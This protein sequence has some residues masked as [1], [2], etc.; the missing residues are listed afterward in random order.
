MKKHWRNSSKVA[1]SLT[2]LSI[3]LFVVLGMP[4]Y[5][6]ALETS[7]GSAVEEY[8]VLAYQAAN[9]KKAFGDDVRAVSPSLDY[10]EKQYL[11]T[12]QKLDR[13][14]IEVGIIFALT[15]SK[16]EF[17]EAV[18]VAVVLGKVG[19][20]DASYPAIKALRKVLLQKVA[21]E[22]M[23]EN[24]PTAR[25][26]SLKKL[27]NTLLGEDRLRNVKEKPA[28]GKSQIPIY[29][30]FHWHMHQPV[31]W[32]YEDMVTT[33]N[34]GVYSFSLLDVMRSRYGPYTSWPFESI[35][36]GS[37]AELPH[38]G[39]QVSFSGA[40]IEDLN[41]MVR[42]G[43]FQNWY[44][45]YT[46]GRRL[47][48]KLGNPRLDLVAFGYHHPL[49]PLTG[50]EDIRRQIRDHKK[51]IQD[52]FGSDVSYSKGIFPP[53]N[54]FAEWIIPA[55]VDEGIEW[56][57]VDNIHFNR[58]CKNYPWVKGENLFPP[59]RADQTNPEQENWIQLSGLWAPSKVS[60]WAYQP[61]Y[62][63]LQDPDT[64]KIVKTPDG[65][66]A[67]MVAVPT[68]R[69]MGNEDGRGGFGALNYEQVMSQLMEY[70]TDPA[71][72][73]LIVLHHDGDNF[74]GGSWGYY[75]DNF[76]RFTDW[77]K[78]RSDLFV[79]T[80]VQDYLQ[81]FPPDD[82]DIIHVEPGSWAG[83][84]NGDPEFHKWNGDPDPETGY[85]PDRNSWGTMT[86]ARN[87]VFT[88]D[89][90]AGSG[91]AAVEGAW[92]YML[93][94]QTSCYEY[95]DGTEMWDSH[96]TRACNQAVAE[97]E[98]VLQG[99][100][101]DRVPPSIYVPQ[102]EPYNP[103]GYEWTAE[104]MSKDFTVWTY[105]YDVSGLEAVD[106]EFRTSDEDKWIS[107]PLAGKDIPSQTNPLP[108]VKA[109]EYTMVIN[110][111]TDKTYLY[112]VKAEDTHGNIGVSPVMKVTVGAAS[113]EP[114]TPVWIPPK[115]T[116]DDII[117][118]FSDRPGYLHWGVNGWKKPA[119]IYWP[120]DSTLWTDGVAIETPMEVFP[121]R[122][123]F[124]TVIGPFNKD[125]QA[126]DSVEFV[127][128]YLDGSWGKDMKISVQ[129][130]P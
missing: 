66:Q 77:I 62:V 27:N 99:K 123:G 18:A 42:L 34:K 129:V 117:I 23:E 84:D 61:H 30:A 24:L 83:A 72:P 22:L 124:Q 37:E 52:T 40:L 112:R 54:A 55:L 111:E 15:L 96:P 63:V 100:Y 110:G 101:D 118:V 47:S 107:H 122:G 7:L 17:N 74:G 14:R 21:G 90:V 60:A 31:Y 105:V 106:L 50:Y 103:G 44:D 75:H 6:R 53:E 12:L 98:K 48:T 16:G 116:Q 87:V 67:K 56:A 25:K 76:R 59:N 26:L 130:A 79:C 36:M 19:T 45:C 51:I 92:R 102:R 64:G 5:C 3:V 35:M 114:D 94:A 128:H 33:H 20:T 46:R 81:L 86:A 85:S 109:K 88:A 91:N 121:E 8:K 70:N 126:V 49:M 1:L 38:F 71:H 43:E 28:A 97:A 93:V 2:G 68:A 89:S 80:T 4:G 120:D 57:F 58:A 65:N 11:L 95:W 13:K 10:A 115:P 113:P 119:E 82:D 29:I 41:A 9:L 78:S 127:Y 69:Y 39:A 108:T 104:P 73:L 32:P 125:V